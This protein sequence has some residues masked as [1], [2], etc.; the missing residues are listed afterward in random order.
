MK[1]KIIIIA[2]CSCLLLAVLNTIFQ[3]ISRS[4]QRKQIQ[5]FVQ[6]QKQFQDA[7]AFDKLHDEKIKHIY[8]RVYVQKLIIDSLSHEA[9]AIELRLKERQKSLAD[10]KKL[11]SRPQ[12]NFADSTAQT[13]LNNLPK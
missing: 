13:I 7:Q 4:K 1:D 12:T 10:I 8:S 5:E 9:A 3:G 11:L 6:L 2:L